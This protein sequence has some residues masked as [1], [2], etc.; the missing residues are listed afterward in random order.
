MSPIDYRNATFESL[1]ER[2]HGLRYLVLEAWRVHG[3]GT[4]REVA[5]RAHMDI[6]TFRPRTTELVQ[7]GFVHLVDE[8]RG[9]TEGRYEALSD[10][11]ARSI[12]EHRRH[13]AIHGFQPELNLK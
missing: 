13:E 11:Q 3:P 10:E 5:E 12:F 9:G 8:E 4:T 6:L 1:R 7:L 2:L